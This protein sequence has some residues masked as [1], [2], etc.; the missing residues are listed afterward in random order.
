MVVKRGHCRNTL[1]AGLIGLMLCLFGL[2]A[3]HYVQ[4]QI[5]VEDATN[6]NVKLE[7]QEGTLQPSE[8]ET[9]RKE[10][11]NWVTEQ[12]SF[13][14]H[15]KLRAD[16]GFS[17]GRGNGA[18]ITGVFIY[19]IWAIELGIVLVLGAVGPV[20]AAKHPYSEKLGRWADE[21]EEAMR[22]PIS[23]DEMVEQIESA[24][25]VEELLE[26]PIPKENNPQRYASYRVHSVAGVEM[27]DAYLSVS[28]CEMSLDKDGNEHKDESEL[29]S[30]AILTADQRVQ[31]LENA[32]LMKEALADYRRAMMEGSL[33]EDD[34]EDE[35]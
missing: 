12:V 25:T 22:L 9:E 26:I 5:L 27:E 29:V 21:T 15:F 2:T 34:E 7:L 16:M 30:N 23:G 18:P 20:G 3:K 31:L 14:G 19:L 33:A 35:A 4:Y 11:R 32:S 8:V 24:T 10:I 13:L 28:L 1:L 6:E 17:I